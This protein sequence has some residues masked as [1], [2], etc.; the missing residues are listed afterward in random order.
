VYSGV[1]ITKTIPAKTL[2]AVFKLA[3]E[4]LGIPNVLQP[5]EFL[6]N[7]D[8]RAILMYITMFKLKF[9]VDPAQ[10]V[11]QQIRQL[12]RLVLECTDG[13]QSATGQFNNDCVKLRSMISTVDVGEK[14]K[15]FEERSTLMD[16]MVR[17]ALDMVE[18]LEERNGLLA[19]ENK[20]LNEQLTVC[21][22]SETPSPIFSAVL[23]S[24]FGSNYTSL[25]IHL[26]PPPSFP[27][28]SPSF[29]LHPPSS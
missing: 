16:S 9:D 28:S 14:E 24:Y 15:F 20:I 18:D 29:S 1:T 8:P 10:A 12:S 7:S 5:T 26:I 22:F 6:Q 2:S 27:P 11:H 17:E 23:Y 3:E 19:R 25:P 4:V 21:F 13:V